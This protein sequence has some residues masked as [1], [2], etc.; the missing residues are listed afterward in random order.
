VIAKYLEAVGA[1]R[2]PGIATF[3]KKNELSGNVTNFPQG[4][5]SPSRPQ[6]GRC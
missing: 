1:E 6:L 5:S 3:I 4:V 2:F